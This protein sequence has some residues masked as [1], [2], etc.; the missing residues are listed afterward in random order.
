MLTVA[1][2]TQ[3]ISFPMVMWPLF[4]SPTNI[5]VSVPTKI[6]PHFNGVNM[7]DCVFPLLHSS[8]GGFY[9]PPQ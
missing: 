6:D 5:L 1:D 4:E 2:L 8:D 9:S 3:S 7:V